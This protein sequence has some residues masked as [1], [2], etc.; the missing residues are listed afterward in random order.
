MSKRYVIVLPVNKE[1]YLKGFSDMI[2]AWNFIQNKISGAVKKTAV[3]AFDRPMMMFSGKAK[4]KTTLAVNERATYLAQLPSAED[5]IL[6]VAVILGEKEETLYPL[7]LNEAN[8]ILELIKE[9]RT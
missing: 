1:P 8:N 7:T 5:D 4:N 3:D 2:L 9:L 6:G